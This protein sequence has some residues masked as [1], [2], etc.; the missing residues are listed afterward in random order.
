MTRHISGYTVYRT[1]EI[2]VNVMKSAM[3]KQ[4]IT[5][6]IQYSQS[7]LN[8]R[9]WRRTET[10]PVPMVTANHLSED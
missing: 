10:M 7:P 2:I 8:G 9:L 6:E 5:T 3:F 4:K 1:I